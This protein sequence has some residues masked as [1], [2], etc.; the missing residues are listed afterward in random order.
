MLFVCFY[1]AHMAY[2]GLVTESSANGQLPCFRRSKGVDGLLRTR[3]EGVGSRQPVRGAG[4][5]EL[6]QGCRSRR[7]LFRAYA[8]CR[9]R[10]ARDFS[11]LLK[12]NNGNCSDYMSAT[13][14]VMDTKPSHTRPLEATGEGLGGPAETN[15]H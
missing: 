10:R 15:I 2:M 11:Q 13:A 7:L 3:Q 8:D 4:C 6:G 5:P 14:C 12:N 9:G 1:T